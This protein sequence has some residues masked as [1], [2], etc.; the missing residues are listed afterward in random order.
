MFFGRGRLGAGAPAPAADAVAGVLG[1][2]WAEAPHPLAR[3]GAAPQRLRKFGKAPEP[4]HPPYAR[5]LVIPTDSLFL[6][7]RLSTPA[8]T[9]ARPTAWRE[10]RTGPQA[11]LLHCLGGW[12]HRVRCR[13]SAAAPT[14]AHSKSLAHSAVLHTGTSRRKQVN[15]YNVLNDCSVVETPKST[16]RGGLY[17]DGFHGTSTATNRRPFNSG[18]GAPRQSLT[19]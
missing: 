5:P 17:Y 7:G 10:H 16:R 6:S 15:C 2:R 13:H 11:G 4:P 9:P 12:R 19:V 1:I 3:S 14:S 8:A 18:S